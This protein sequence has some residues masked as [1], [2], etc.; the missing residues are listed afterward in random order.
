MNNIW[1][2]VGSSTVVLALVVGAG[3][4][5]AQN[6]VDWTSSSAGSVPSATVTFSGGTRTL[7]GDAAY[8]NQTFNLANMTAPVSSVEGIEFRAA[9]STATVYTVSFSSAVTGVMLH[10]GSLAST[11]TFDRPITKLSG[12]ANFVVNGNSL[13]GSSVNSGPFSDANGSVYLGDL[14]TFSFSVGAF[15]GGEG[16]GLQMVTGVA[17]IPEAGAMWLMLA[18]LAGLGLHRKARTG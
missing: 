1:N 9:G 11:I 14:Q 8:V 15:P 12:Q 5:G 17:P 4:A 18:G 2:S 10:I 7:V 6:V 16:I 3:N 13:T